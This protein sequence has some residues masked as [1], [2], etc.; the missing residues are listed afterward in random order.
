MNILKNRT[1]AIALAAFIVLGSTAA[2]VS[3]KLNKACNDVTKTFYD[4]VNHSGYLH[5]SISS[6]L[7]QILVSADGLVTLASSYGINTSDVTAAS[8]NLKSALSEYT[9]DIDDIY[10]LYSDLLSAENSLMYNMQGQ[11]LSE[12]DSDGFEQYKG[13]LS[14]ANNVIDDAGYNELVREFY[15]DNGGLIESVFI[16]LLDIDTPETFA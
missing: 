14:G 3:S 16:E 10:E 2:T 15:D 11:T 4:G 12:R 13:I 1:I 5:K 6:Q 9:D 8:R 7:N